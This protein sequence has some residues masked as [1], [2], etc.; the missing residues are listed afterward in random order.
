MAISCVKISA[1][2]FKYRYE[3]TNFQYQIVS[4]NLTDSDGN[5]QPI[6]HPRTPLEDG[7][8]LS[9]ALISTSSKSNREA[10]TRWLYDIDSKIKEK[11]ASLSNTMK[12]GVLDDNW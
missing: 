2:D 3:I 5:I 1:K 7:L 6:N 8:A 10:G 9:S 12:I 4:W 11:I